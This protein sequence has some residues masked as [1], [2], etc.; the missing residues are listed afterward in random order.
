M[1]LRSR[2][3]KL[4]LWALLAFVFVP[5]NPA[6][7][8]SKPQPLQPLPSQMLAAHMSADVLSR[9]LYEPFTLDNEASAK[10]FDNYI[11]LLD[12]EKI[13]FTQS[14]IDRLENVRGSL[15]DAILH[16]DLTPPFDVF[17]LY[18]ER[19]SER[20]NYAISLLDRGGFNF[21]QQ[22]EYQYNRKHAPWAKSTEELND[23]W[24][25]RVK[26]DWLRLKLAGKDG[27]SI[28]ETLKKRYENA[29]KSLGKLKSEDAFQ[30][31]M[32]A[33]A[34]TTDPHTDYFGVHATE[35]FN[36]SMKLSLVGIGAVLITQ[37]EYTTIKE[38][39]PGGPAGLSGKLKPGDRI[40]GVGQGENSVPVD[41]LGWRIDDTVALIRGAEDTTVLLDILPAEAGPDG[42]HKLVSLVRKKISLEKQAARKSV[43]EVKDGN[44][45]HRIGIITLPSFYKD[46]GAQQDGD[47]NFK[48]ASRDVAHLLDELKQEKIDSVLIDLR[49]NGG[50]SLDEAIDMT[51][52]F[53]DK[54]PVVQER[55]A[56][57]KV[58]V[59]NDT[60]G[61]TSWDG[62]LGVLINRA[63]A[64]AS[65][66]FAAAIQDYGRG[67]IIGERSFGKGTVQSVVNLDQM[68]HN[69]KPEYGEVK[70]TIAQFFRING[71]TTQLRGVIPDIPF[72]TM[73]DETEFGESSFDNALPW[74]Q[75][76]PADY[77]PAGDLSAYI[78]TLVKRHDNRAKS[79]REYQYLLE[80]IS[81]MR[82]QRKKNLISLNEAVR[83]KEREDQEARQ[84]QRT[85]ERAAVKG[86]KA[87]EKNTQ[88]EDDGLQAN[89]RSV[90]T[91]LAMEQAS[92]DAKDVLL[93][94]AAHILSDEVSLFKNGMKLTA[95]R[96]PR[97]ASVK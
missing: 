51:G 86:A 30:D 47:K 96:A 78:P 6:W 25:K 40:V 55:D 53:I 58:T 62:P 34:T 92:K 5:F 81:E 77:T 43:I 32:T 20:L 84:K 74:T 61:G 54:G 11:K 17:N 7:A 39:V 26:N 13:Y 24:R 4:L 80:D 46:F 70:M 42:Q 63:S 72:P 3:G 76:K 49:N 50:G 14:D 56:R 91:E 37:D 79:S 41:V 15:D 90:Q 1:V 71:G 35:E 66:I 38:L 27:K 57:G 52:L 31:F 12:S 87:A 93:D 22:E 33:Y 16:E 73:V 64:S 23:L 83:R 75:I 21:E 2:T 29:L 18:Q 48:S 82:K 65:E 19:A 69:K 44:V 59:S 85:A 60:H 95:A 45:K 10:I 28:A 97:T 88:F 67:L 68:A 94:E 89:E 9:Y 36:I 8:L